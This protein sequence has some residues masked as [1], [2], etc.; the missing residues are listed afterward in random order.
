MWQARERREVYKVLMGKPEARIPL[1][2]PRPRWDDGIRI[3]LREIGLRGE[4]A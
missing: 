1:R 2:R 3:D 4:L